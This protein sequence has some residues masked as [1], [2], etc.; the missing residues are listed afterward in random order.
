M[1][2][3]DEFRP[4]GEQS[5]T[6]QNPAAISEMRGFIGERYDTDAGLE[7][8]N[9]RYYDPRLGMFIQP[10]WWEVTRAGVG[11]NRYAYSFGDPVN[12]RDPTGHIIDTVWDVLSLVY[13]GAKLV[14]G[15]YTEDDALVSEATEDLV[16]DTF[17]ALTPGV[18]AGAS[19]VARATKALAGKVAR[20]E[21]G[22]AVKR[23]AIAAGRYAPGTGQKLHHIVETANNTAEAR[24]LRD[25]LDQLGIPIDSVDNAVGLV[26]HPG[27]HINDYAKALRD[28]LEGLKT[29]EEGLRE[30]EKISREL[31]KIDR[32]LSNGTRKGQAVDRTG[33]P[34]A[35]KEWAKDQNT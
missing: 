23:E 10:D 7:Y 17:S 34:D 30:L 28:R 26:N 12:G 16:V 1:D 3:F 5:E 19:K 14:K 13:D 11:T 2:G 9:A 31:Q 24:Q 27:S 15:W 8:L 6:V 18:P 20:K 35:T 4:F 25:I 32:E 22:A 21:F 29:R 33:K